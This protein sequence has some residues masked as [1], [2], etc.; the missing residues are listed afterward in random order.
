MKIATAT[1]SHVSP[2]GLSAAS[3]PIGMIA[4]VV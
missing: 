3:D 1:P 4:M 2:E